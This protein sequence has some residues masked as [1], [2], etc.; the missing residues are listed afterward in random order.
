M[1]YRICIIFYKIKSILLSCLKY[2]FITKAPSATC[3]N[4]P[5]IHQAPF[6]EKSGSFRY[7]VLTFSI[8]Q[9]SLSLKTDIMLSIL[10]KIWVDIKPI[11]NSQQVANLSYNKPEPEKIICH[12][13]SQS[14]CCKARKNLI[15]SCFRGYFHFVYLSERRFLKHLHFIF[16]IPSSSRT[17]QT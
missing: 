14:V 4:R 7:L 3:H 13:S 10:R 8:S 17:C 6:S 9:I 16:Y 11:L 2:L 15:I 12:V 5:D 1:I